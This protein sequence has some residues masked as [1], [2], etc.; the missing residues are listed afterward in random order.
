M[1]QRKALKR[2]VAVLF[3][4]L[5]F[6]DLALDAGCDPLSLP[7]ARASVVA[8]RDAAS[9]SADEPCGTVCVPDCFCC[10]RTLVGG[11][12][13]VPTTLGLVTAAPEGP[14]PAAPVGVHPVPYHPPLGRA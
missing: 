11:L 7:T 5:A 8:A 2:F 9:G 13:V 4:A 10:S 6:A 1:P 3:A 14:P 12:A